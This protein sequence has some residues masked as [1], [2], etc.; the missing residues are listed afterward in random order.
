MLRGL[1]RVAAQRY[2]V[3]SARGSGSRAG[4]P[5]HGVDLHS[6]TMTKPGP[7]VRRAM[8]E[9][10]VGDDDYG[11]DPNVCGLQEKAAELL[12][13]EQTLFVPTN[14]T[15]NLISG[16]H[17]V[18]FVRPP[19]SP[20]MLLPFVLGAVETNMVTVKVDGLPPEEL[21]GHLQAA[22]AGEVA[23]AG[24]A[25][26]VLLFPWKKQSVRAMWH[27]DI[28]AQDTELTCQSPE[29]EETAREPGGCRWPP[30]RPAR[31]ERRRPA[32]ASG[33][34]C[35]PPKGLAGG[36]DSCRLKLPW[37]LAARMVRLLAQSHGVRVHLD[38][39]ADERR[40]SS[41]PPMLADAGLSP[42]NPSPDG[43]T[44]SALPC[45]LMTPPPAPR[46]E[47]HTQGPSGQDCLLFLP[48][49]GWGS[50]VGGTKDFI[51]E[52]WRLRKA[53]GGGTRQAVV[54]AA[55][56]LV[57][58]AEAE[59]VLSRDHRNAQ[60]FAKGLQ[61]LASICSVDLSA[62]ETNM[63]TVKVDGLPPEELC[64][65]LQAAS[66]GEVA[67][68]GH[69]VRVLLFPWKK[70]SVRAMWH[71]DISAQDTELVLKKREFVLRKL[72]P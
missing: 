55:A 11:E 36:E 63:V 38:R 12:G 10:V 69:A 61:E 44:V 14:T 20:S 72:G 56:A 31:R 34:S 6:D 16:E 8:A 42:F 65:H 68:A 39:P 19:G 71:R 66:A 64:G 2:G 27:R 49:P 15:A 28:S 26:R 3:R 33:R 21:C 45:P 57:G 9:A 67:P 41:A 58:L 62:V 43:A 48:G 60:R 25:V 50:L 5:A 13:V 1:V 37:E 52:A 59:E 29:C 7:A 54:L 22:S 17:R 47:T 32:S 35:E 23:P 51:K 40:S 24:H 70:Q 18:P 53:L 46:T 30:V 4:V